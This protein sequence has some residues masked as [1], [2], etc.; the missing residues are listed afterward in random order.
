MFIHTGQTASLKPVKM[1]SME[2]GKSVELFLSSKH[3]PLLVRLT[4]A[5]FDHIYKYIYFKKT[6]IFVLKI[7]GSWSQS[8]QPTDEG[9][10]HPGKPQV[11][12]KTE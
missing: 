8:Q 4:H 3:C 7:A 1:Y 12:V 11:M 9:A 5:A 2:D 10:V 6:Y